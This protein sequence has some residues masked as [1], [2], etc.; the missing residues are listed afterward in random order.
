MS[1]ERMCAHLL[2]ES[3]NRTTPGGIS[4][5]QIQPTSLARHIATLT[6]WTA[7]GVLMLTM[8][9]AWITR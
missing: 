9:A 8:C 7:F 6:A 1:A 3:M 2:L 5:Q 4:R